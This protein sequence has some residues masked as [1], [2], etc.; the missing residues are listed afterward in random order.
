MSQIQYNC[1]S[2]VLD[3]HLSTNVAVHK[4][5]VKWNIKMELNVEKMWSEI[6]GG[7]ALGSGSNV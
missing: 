6:I 1:L 2:C 3:S 5:K 4:M 7:G